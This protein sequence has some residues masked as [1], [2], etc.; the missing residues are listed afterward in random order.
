MGATQG[1][2]LTYEF[3]CL[4]VAKTPYVP[5]PDARSGPTGYRPELLLAT[6]GR[7]FAS[8]ATTWSW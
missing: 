7:V 4:F 2:A 5:G 8:Q 3:L 1:T 6:G